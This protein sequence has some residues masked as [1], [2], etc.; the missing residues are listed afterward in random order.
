MASAGRS[1]H[2]TTTTPALSKWTEFTP[3]RD[4]LV[5]ER[6]VNEVSA[7]RSTH[8]RRQQA[9]P[10]ISRSEKSLNRRKPIA[11]FPSWMDSNAGSPDASAQEQTLTNETRR[12]A[13]GE[14]AVT[15]KNRLQTRQV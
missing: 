2:H 11:L 7:G 13:R 6:V 14:H 10:I 12:F 8:Q 9:R 4:R 1:I 3:Y 15:E 5:L